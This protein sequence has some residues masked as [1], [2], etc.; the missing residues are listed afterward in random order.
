MLVVRCLRTTGKLIA[1]VGLCGAAMAMEPSPAYTARPVLA[2]ATAQAS[3]TTLRRFDLPRMPLHDALQRYS[4]L[5]GRSVLYDARQ[6]AGRQSSAV[7]GRFTADV[8]LQTLIRG[9]G[10]QTRFASDDA[11]MLVPIPAPKKPSTR[12]AS[13]A[14]ASA[15]PVFYGQVQARVT[16]F[17]CTDAALESGRYRL[18]LRFRINAAQAIEQLQVHATGRA[19]LEPRIRAR[20]EGLALGVAPPP[21]VAQ[22][23]LLLIEPQRTSGRKACGP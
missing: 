23:I 2:G 6:V 10:M 1:M 22:P 7:V 9:S 16:H 17:L 12:N 14:P 11:F 13:R 21:G 3:D 19:D 18:A 4:S 15:Y 5:T 20:L 8:A